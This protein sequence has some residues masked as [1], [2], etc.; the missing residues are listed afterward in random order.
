M[1]FILHILRK[2]RQVQQIIISAEKN[3]KTFASEQYTILMSIEKYI[4]YWN[5]T[6]V[7]CSDGTTI[8]PCSFH[9]I[10]FEASHNC[11]LCCS[12]VTFT[13]PIPKCIK[14]G[15]T[16]SVIQCRKRIGASPRGSEE[17]GCEELF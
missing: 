4:I 17:A 7:S 6:W 5:S 10:E 15:E 13:I 16:N 9:L 1:Y 12:N 3:A 11:I 14:L 2:P 8:L